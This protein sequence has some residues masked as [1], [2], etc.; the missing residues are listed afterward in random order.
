M[1]TED[2]FG[3]ICPTPSKPMLV[4]CKDDGNLKSNSVN[5]YKWT[6]L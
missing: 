2:T 3:E 1:T 6:Q 4:T 5:K